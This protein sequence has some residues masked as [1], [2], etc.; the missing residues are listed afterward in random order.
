MKKIFLNESEKRKLILEKEKL[1]ME[2]FAKT[3][4]KIKRIDENEISTD[5]GVNPSPNYSNN[6]WNKAIVKI[7][8][9]ITV[10]N[11]PDGEPTRGYENIK[12]G[13]VLTITNVRRNANGI[14]YDTDF[15]PEYGIDNDDIQSFT[16]KFQGV[17]ENNHEDYELEDRK[18]QYGINPEIDPLELQD[19]NEPI[20]ENTNDTYFESLSEALDAVR[21]K[22]EK[23]GF[24]I[25]EEAIWTSFGTGGISYETTKSANIPLLQN[26]QPILDKRGKEANRYIRVSIYRMPSGRYELTMYKTW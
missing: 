26:G 21:A 20:S 2:S 10:S 14:V 17:D 12:I 13:D 4:N 11:L 16:N 19:I 5:I 15:S 8:D 7:G 18:Q 22:A 24:E 23:L 3:F 1:I 6:N 25:D 9:K